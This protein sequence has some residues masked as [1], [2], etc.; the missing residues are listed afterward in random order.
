MH[1]TA[2]AAGDHTIHG[3]LGDLRV[4]AS[5]F[6][7]P[8]TLKV[9]SVAGQTLITAGVGQLPANLDVNAKV[10]AGEICVDGRRVASGVG[11]SYQG[12]LDGHVTGSGASAT[13][14]NPQLDVHQVFGQI[15]IGQQGCQR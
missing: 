1:A 6:T 12:T 8:G 13:T 2:P 4:D 9:E 7:G 3:G 11:A 10:L 14:G 5:A 15:Q